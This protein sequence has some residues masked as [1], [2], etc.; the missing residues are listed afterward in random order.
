MR[1]GRLC[2]GD[3]PCIRSVG[4][5]APSGRSLH[6]VRGR[7]GLPEILRPDCA[8]GINQYHTVWADEDDPERV[9]IGE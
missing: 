6:V 5:D 7:L 9:M 3:G 4:F 8:L 1:R 2:P